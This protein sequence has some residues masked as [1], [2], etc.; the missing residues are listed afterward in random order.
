M[1]VVNFNNVCNVTVIIFR[2]MFT[3]IVHAYPLAFTFYRF[4]SLRNVLL[5]KD[6]LGILRPVAVYV[7]PHFFNI[8]KFINACLRFREGFNTSV[9]T[10]LKE[11]FSTITASELKH[12][13]VT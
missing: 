13:Y 3:Y 4:I 2:Y 7:H 11:R 12:K 10:V 9:Q 8:S 6:L 1:Y 5:K